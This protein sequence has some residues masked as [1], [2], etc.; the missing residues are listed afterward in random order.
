MLRKLKELVPK[1]SVTGIGVTIVEKLNFAWKPTPEV[2]TTELQAAIERQSTPILRSRG[3]EIQSKEHHDTTF[4]FLR[5]DLEN[6]GEGVAQHLHVRP[7]LVASYGPNQENQTHVDIEEA[8]FLTPDGGVELGPCYFE[9]TR[10]RSEDSTVKGGVLHPNDGVVSF[11]AQ[12]EFQNVVRGDGGRVKRSRVPLKEAT[13][14]LYEASFHDLSFQVHVLY[15][16]VNKRVHAE[17]VM[18]KTGEFA[19]GMTLQDIADMR[20]SSESPSTD[21]VL[22]RIEETY[23]YPP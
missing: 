21:K 13:Q 17:Q 23:L 10:V 15:V 2:D 19:G 6:N 5:I 18:G 1:F 3:M 8:C 4:D 22:G 9:L 14:S 20:F 11:S 12:I 16:D 7:T